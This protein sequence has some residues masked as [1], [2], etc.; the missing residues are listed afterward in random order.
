MWKCGS[1]AWIINILLTPRTGACRQTRFLELA[2]AH[3]H[4]A[5]LG[6]LSIFDPAAVR[7]API[8]A[9]VGG[10]VP[11]ARIGPGFAAS[12]TKLYLFGGFDG[13]GLV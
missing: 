12:G 3:T 6:N 1:E 13:A 8:P 11:S 7:W 9:L 2:H 4:T 10:A 5:T